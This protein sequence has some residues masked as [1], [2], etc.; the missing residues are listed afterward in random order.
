MAGPS[1]VHTLT[2]QHSQ[3]V[4]GMQA[5]TIQVNH[6]SQAH[7]NAAN[8]VNVLNRATDD[9]AV[10]GRRGAMGILELSRGVEDAAV[11]FG[12]GGLQGAIRGSLNNLTMFATLVGGPLTG[13]A[14][15]F[16]AAGISMAA[17]FFKIGQGSDEAKKSIEAFVEA[18]Q[19]MDEA[20]IG[21]IQGGRGA[22]KPEEISK[23]MKEQES[24]AE[25]ASLSLQA[26]DAR[27]ARARQNLAALREERESVLFTTP[28]TEAQAAFERID[29]A[30]EENEALIAAE[31]EGRA[32]LAAAVRA[33]NQVMAEARREL[34]P[35]LAEAQ[36]NAFE[37]AERE[38]TADFREQARKDLEEF[39]ALEREGQLA[40]EQA[41]DRLRK[42]DDER[43]ER[44]AGRA[45]KNMG[46]FRPTDPIM[47]GS[48]EAFDIIQRGQQSS[49]GGTPQDIVKEIKILTDRAEQQKR[50][51]DEVKRI[52][53]DKLDFER[54]EA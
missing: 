19:S 38:A 24:A 16:V 23:L 37:Q 54:F 49:A 1:T 4:A 15:G 11:S 20:R 12:T 44:L 41:E 32:K 27:A 47:S 30:I 22:R 14:A 6:V 8:G 53:R 33:T 7:R 48:R 10:S 40:G 46:G 3:Y 51:L 35:K 25:K 34:G 26:S 13:A 43:I 18:A 17:T 21:L 39:K 45:M 2:T 28:A 9:A 31:E 42:R 5:V 50:V 36:R 29:K 52:L